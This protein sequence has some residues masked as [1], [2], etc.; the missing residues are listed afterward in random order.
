MRNGLALLLVLSV[1]ACGGSSKDMMGKTGAAGTGQI[2]TG[3]AGSSGNAGSSGAA[4]SQGGTGTAGKAGGTGTAGKTGSA[5]GTGAAGSTASGSGGSGPM[6][7]TGNPNPTYT[8]ARELH[9]ALTGS[10][11][12]DGSMAT[13]F[14]TISKVTPMAKAGDCILV[15][16]GT[17]AESAT[18][19][20][21]NDGTM[22]APIVLRSADG[23]LKAVIDAKTNRGGPTVLVRNDYVIIDG[24]EFVNSPMDTEEQVIHFDGLNAKAKCT[25]DV[26][27]NCKLTAGYDTIKCNENSQG[28]TIEFNEIYGT[29]QHLPVS[30]TGAS[31]FTFR[32]N[33]CHDWTLDGDGAVQIKGGSHDALFEGNVFQDV[34]TDA[35][36]IAMGDGCDSTCDVDPN[37]YAGVRIRAVNNVFVRVGRGLDVQGCKDCAILNNTFVD[38][39]VGNVMLKL[40]SAATNGTTTA[41]VNARIMNNL[42]VNSGNGGNVMQINSPAG[43]GLMMDYNLRWNGG[44]GVEWGDGHPATADTHSVTKDPKLTSAT[45]FSLAA[46]SAALGAGTNLFA[47]VPIDFKGAARPMTGAFDIGAY[48]S[49]P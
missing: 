17:Y 8:C 34:H 37:H 16:A 32:G 19:G 31:N 18:I 4:G 6:V 48:Q 28:V 41:T 22:A 40:T 20:F 14:R 24:F 30:L 9:V 10:D 13:P 2:V 39:G 26:L 35:G 46:G 27:R 29:F 45:D 7:G 5:G 43:M 12:N 33:F 38:S 44:M 11:T 36:A 1:A 21:S 49:S 15:H 47:D 23:K 3:G 42:L 25:G